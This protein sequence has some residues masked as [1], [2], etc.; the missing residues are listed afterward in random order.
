MA[1]SASKEETKKGQKV[2]RVADMEAEI[3]RYFTIG[4]TRKAGHAGAIGNR[5]H[6]KEEQHQQHESLHDS[7][8]SI[9]D[10]P[11]KPFLGFGTSGA[12]SVSPVDIVKELDAKY[13]PSRSQRDTRSLSRS[14]SYLTW[15]RSSAPPRQDDC[16]PATS[17]QKKPTV[18]QTPSFTGRESISGAVSASFLGNRAVGTLLPKSRGAGTAHASADGVANIADAVSRQGANLQIHNL[19]NCEPLQDANRVQSSHLH[20]HPDPDCLSALKVSQSGI[21]TTAAIETGHPIESKPKLVVKSTKPT[22]TLSSKPLANQEALE[23]IQSTLNALLQACK[24]KFSNAATGDTGSDTVSKP[25]VISDAAMEEPGRIKQTSSHTIPKSLTLEE[26]GLEYRL[27][28]LAQNA[29]FKLRDDPRR[30]DDSGQYDQLLPNLASEQ[31]LIANNLDCR[32]Y[33]ADMICHQNLHVQRPATE[34]TS[35]LKGYDAFLE[36]QWR[37]ETKLV[38]RSGGYAS[39]TGG[40]QYG[41][42][43]NFDMHGPS[44]ATESDEL[45]YAHPMIDESV[46]IDE[47]E[48]NWFN[49]AA[50]EK[51]VANHKIQLDETNA[52]YQTASHYLNTAPPTPPARHHQ[53]FQ[54]RTS[55]GQPQY[56][57]DLTVGGPQSIRFRADRPDSTFVE[58]TPAPK[59]AHRNDML[60]TLP[61]S[62]IDEDHGIQPV[63]FWKPNRLY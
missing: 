47:L 53:S 46:A 55:Q 62:R 31:H 17:R 1:E 48:E 45:P 13:V 4:K 44:Y 43:N 8:P 39:D 42:N 56:V 3:S 18:C 54:L 29:H 20:Q 25:N 7:V 11:E 2:K 49:D 63:G 52:N 35:I 23:T 24:P 27:Q 58:H 30:F 40:S 37:G 36:Q 5:K 61:L 19:M 21:P 51:L 9:I 15:S 50:Q 16:E 12:N 59:R 10:L 6:S 60:Q 32:P 26:P 28:P 57:N 41:D 38:D 14:T 22:V 34:P 33:T